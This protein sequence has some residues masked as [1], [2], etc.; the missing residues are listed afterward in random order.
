MLPN[1]DW[2]IPAYCYNGGCSPLKTGFGSGWFRST[3]GGKTWDKDYI[4]RDDGP[5]GDLGYPCS[6]ELS[7]GK[8]LTVYYQ[9]KEAGG[10]CVI[11]QSIW[12]I[13]EEITKKIKE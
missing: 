4:L 11:M 10:Y 1:G 2:M 3:D 12:E 6:I 8:I 13:P 9:Q 7:D 5:S